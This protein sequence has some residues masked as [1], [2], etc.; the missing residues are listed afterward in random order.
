MFPAFRKGINMYIIPDSKIYILRNVPL[1][2]GYEHTIYFA[3]ATAQFNYFNSLA[4]FRETRYS[5]IRPNEPQ[6]KVGIKSD[7][8]YDCNYIMFQNTSFGNK[9]FYAYIKSIDYVNNE[10]SLITYELDTMQTW[11]FDFTIDQCFVERTHTVTDRIGEHIEPEPVEP[12]EYVFNSYVNLWPFSNLITIIAI[13]NINQGADVGLIDGITAGCE[14]WAFIPTDK[15]GINSK[16][17]EYIQSPDSIV[18]MYMVPQQFLDETVSAGGTH[19]SETLQAKKIDLPELSRVTTT[20]KLDGYTPRNCKLYTYPYSFYHVDNGAGSSL[21]LRYEF[22]KDG[23]IHLEI[24]CGITQPVQAILYPVNYK[25]SDPP[26]SD[27][28]TMNAMN[29]IVS[30]FPMCSW[31][32]DAYEAWVAQNSMQL[33]TTAI[34]GYGGALVSAFTGNPV[35]GVGQALNTTI[36]LLNQDYKASIAADQMRGSASAGNINSAAKKNQFYGG[37]MSITAQ[38]ARTID[39]FFD[40]FGYGVKR[41]MKPIL[42]ARPYWTYIKTVGATITGSVPCDDMRKIIKIFDSGVTFWTSGSVV[43]HYELNNQAAQRG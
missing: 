39:D 22:A 18:A 37:R 5:Y 15:D 23:Y 3:T 30:G 10:T 33:A 25:D 31:N 13:V 26:T 4:K 43:G 7:D 24:D 21:I 11:F 20:R 27:D 34:S 41:L 29:L 19:L 17:Q 28:R 14:L 40:R 1:D 38:Y 32:V 8:L 35:G 36:N 42:N 9:W 6:I 12:G 2:T 16:L